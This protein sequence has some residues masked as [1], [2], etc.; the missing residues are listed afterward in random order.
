MGVIHMPSQYYLDHH[1]R[2]ENLCEEYE[3]SHVDYIQYRA[4]R[5]RALLKNEKIKNEELKNAN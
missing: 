4:K 3:K 5:I 2:L 1:A